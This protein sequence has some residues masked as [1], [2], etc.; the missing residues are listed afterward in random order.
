MHTRYTTKTYPG[1]TTGSLLVD[2][3]EVDTDSVQTLVHDSV[4][5]LVH[6]GQA[7]ITREVVS[8]IEAGIVTVRGVTQVSRAFS[9]FVGSDRDRANSNA[10]LTISNLHNNKHISVEMLRPCGSMLSKAQL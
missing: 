9:S 5:A 3:K 4:Q 7:G 1:C 2:R 6:T 10:L 8:F